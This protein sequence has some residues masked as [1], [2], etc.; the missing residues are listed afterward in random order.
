MAVVLGIGLR[1][2]P[3]LVGFGRVRDDMGDD[4]DGKADSIEAM[5]AEKLPF[6]ETMRLVLSNKVLWVLAIG[7]FCMNSVRYSFMNWAV[8]YMADFQGQPIK[9]SAFMAVALPLIGAIGAVSAGWM[10][11][12]LFHKRRAPLCAI[13]LFSLAAVCIGFIMIPKGYAGV[14]TAMLGLAGFLIYGPDMLMSGAATADVHPKAAAA[15]TGFTMAMGNFGAMISGAGIGWLRDITPTLTASM[16][17]S[18][19]PEHAA[20]FSAWTLIFLLLSVL[21]IL[22]A[23]L[24]VSIWNAKPKGS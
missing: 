18:L 16:R 7:Y 9:H 13:M 21:S 10:S 23:L 12:K 2:D 20:I 17:D 6:A 3:R 1:D 4:N 22:S 15:A 5:E 8:T 24:M 14:A 19:P 11:D